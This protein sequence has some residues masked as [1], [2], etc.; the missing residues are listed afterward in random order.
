MTV[1]GKKVSKD[2]MNSSLDEES[3]LEDNAQMATVIVQPAGRNQT[4]DTMWVVG[5]SLL[6]C[7]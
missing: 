3:H 2:R 4:E 7:P 5:L 6:S 1:F